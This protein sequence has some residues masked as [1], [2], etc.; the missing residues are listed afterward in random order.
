MK[1]FTINIF[2]AVLLT[3]II[4]FCLGSCST[5]AEAPKLA[6]P[7][8]QMDE[9]DNP[10]IGESFAKLST[11]VWLDGGASIE[12]VGVCWTIKKTSDEGEVQFP[13]KDIDDTSIGSFSNNIA[14]AEIGALTVLDTIYYARFYAINRDGVIGYSYPFKFSNNLE[15]Y[16][17]N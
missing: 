6:V 5:D 8:F 15:D 4:S 12:E 3:M 7:G 11:R 10:I 17:F 13:E 16:D 1:N 14:Y 2:K 9:N